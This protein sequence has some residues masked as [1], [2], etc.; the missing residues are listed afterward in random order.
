M[1]GRSLT[2]HLS[3]LFII[4]IAACV[5]SG[6]APPIG[7]VGGS[8]SGYGNDN[9]A[10]SGFD[11]LWIIPNRLFYEKG[12][13]FNVVE[14]LQIFTSDS[15][16]TRQVSPAETGVTITISEIS[17]FGDPKNPTLVGPAP[18]VFS[19]PGIYFIEVGY[20]SKKAR[21]TVE[22]RGYYVESGDGSDFIDII[23][24]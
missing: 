24:L 12:D 23:W 9:G 15:G 11:A 20:N 3:G 4:G 10:D 6:C 13:Y 19:L 22:V 18:Y 21:Y 7:F 8:G 16:L 2:K 5:L 14:D 1:T 17:S